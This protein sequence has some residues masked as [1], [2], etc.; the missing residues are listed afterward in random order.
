MRRGTVE[1]PE[2]RQKANNREE[3]VK[4]GPDDTPVNVIY[5]WPLSFPRRHYLRE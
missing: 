4:P 5:G 2:C 1:H 3:S